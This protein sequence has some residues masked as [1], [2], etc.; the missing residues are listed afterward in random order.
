M[1]LIV[2]AEKA[3]CSILNIQHYS[4]V[5]YNDHL[6]NKMKKFILLF[7]IYAFVRSKQNYSTLEISITST[8]FTDGKHGYILNSHN[9]K[10]N[11]IYSIEGFPSGTILQYN[12]I[13][14]PEIPKYGTYEVIVK[15]V[16]A[17]GL[18]G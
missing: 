7:V 1:D 16:D 3:L 4:I 11:I 9:G 14:L 2:Q 5:N 18:K 6:Y 15:G 17:N 13:Y 8:L 10:G 12:R